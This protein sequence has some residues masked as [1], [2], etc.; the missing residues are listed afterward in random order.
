GEIEAVVKQHPAVRDAVVLA[1]EERAGDRRLVGYVGVEG[2]APAAGGLRAFPAAAVPDY[3]VP[4]AWVTLASMPVTP[5]GKV[6]R[7]A[8]PAPD[9]T[10]DGASHVEPR[11]PTEQAIAEIWRNV[12]Q[13]QRV[14][15]GDNFF[16]LGGH[17]LLATQVV[18]Q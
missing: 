8:L 14:G 2:A 9:I 3:M 5:N 12:L 18:T 13:A 6:D 15:A 7:R 10:G 4:T 1:R 11:T 17:S 16:L